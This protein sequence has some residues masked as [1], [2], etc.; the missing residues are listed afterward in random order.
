MVHILLAHH[1]FIIVQ[2][3]K[4]LIVEQP[5][6]QV[7]QASIQQLEA[8]ITAL[9]AQ[10]QAAM[11]ALDRRRKQFAMLMYCVEEL[12]QAIA[13]EEAGGGEEGAVAMQVDD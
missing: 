2:G 8:D 10:K 13:E 1:I 11:H 9:E 3:I 7:T 5:S 12:Q 4:K 6:R